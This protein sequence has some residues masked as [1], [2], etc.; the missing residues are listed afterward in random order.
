[1][2]I[3]LDTFLE[4]YDINHIDYLWIDA[5]GSD[6]NV[7]QSLGNKIRIVK[8]GKCEGSER[9]NLYKNIDNNSR[10]IAQYLQ[11]HGFSTLIQPIGLGQES[12]IH[13]KKR[14]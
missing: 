1:M 9:V 6:F 13:F 7:L 5:Q 2:T 12:D 4:L 8:E 14:I 11:Q 10:N 3:R